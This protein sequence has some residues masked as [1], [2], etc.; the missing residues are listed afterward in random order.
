V[1]VRHVCVCVCVCVLRRDGSSRLRIITTMLIV[2]YGFYCSVENR[3]LV[4]LLTRL[5]E[6]RP[7]LR[8]RVRLSREPALSRKSSVSEPNRFR[9][10]VLILAFTCYDG[11]RRSKRPNAVEKSFTPRHVDAVSSTLANVSLCRPFVVRFDA[12]NVTYGNAYRFGSLRII[13]YDRHSIRSYRSHE[14]N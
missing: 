11:V 10:R 3:T 8:R 13:A 1:C 7:R 14:V 12:S 6:K 5:D 2:R 9:F 4:R